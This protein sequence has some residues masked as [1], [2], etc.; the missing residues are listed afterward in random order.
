MT[1]IEFV[2]LTPMMFLILM[3][4]VQFAMYL[5][6]KQAAQ[7][8]VQ[9]GARKAREEAAADGCTGAGNQVD[10]V[11]WSSGL[12][13]QQDA[14]NEVTIRAAAV[15]GRLLTI[16]STSPGGG[17]TVDGTYNPNPNVTVKCQISVVTVTLT[18][19]PPS[20]VP[21]WQPQIHVQSGGPLEQGVVHK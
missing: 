15:G 18:A 19:D 6:A 9:A 8:A 12:P 7:A 3:L 4:T 16:D 2:I 13:W 20:I 11:N 1:A 14:G 21:F 10:K 5:F 17:I